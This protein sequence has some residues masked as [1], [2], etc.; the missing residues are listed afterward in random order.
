LYCQAIEVNDKNSFT[1]T[2][3]PGLFEVYYYDE[4]GQA[5]KERFMIDEDNPVYGINGTK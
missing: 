1:F 3:I 5:H 4:A 2:A